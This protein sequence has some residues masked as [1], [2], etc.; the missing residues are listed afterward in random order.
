[1]FSSDQA[2]AGKKLR[3]VSERKYL[4]ISVRKEDFKNVDLIAGQ[5]AQ[6]RQI[7]ELPE[8]PHSQIIQSVKDERMKLFLE[9]NPG[10]IQLL[11][12]KKKKK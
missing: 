2:P 8:K 7:L 3:S 9:H 6:H 4:M 12:N 5:L 1:M 10:T 11:S